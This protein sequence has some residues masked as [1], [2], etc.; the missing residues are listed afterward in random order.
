MPKHNRKRT[1]RP[2]GRLAAAL[3]LFRRPSA[4]LLLAALGVGVIAAVMVSGSAR[5]TNVPTSPANLHGPIKTPFK[6]PKRPPFPAASQA[7][8]EAAR[9]AK[10]RDEAF[11]VAERVVELLPDNPDALCLLGSVHHRFACDEAAA[12]LWQRS[13]DIDPGFADAHYSFGLRANS[14]GDF[15]AAENHLRT[16]LAIDPAWSDVPLPLAQALLAQ[17]KFK[18]AA[19]LLAPFV[20][21]YPASLEGWYRLGQAYHQLGE[22]EQARRCHLEAVSLNPQLADAHHGAA[23]ALTKLGQTEEAERH[24]TEFRRLREEQLR[25][26][27]AEQ[28]GLTDEGRLAAAAAKTHLTAGR[29]FARQGQ[30]RKAEQHWQRA[31]DLDPHDHESRLSLCE[32]YARQGQHSEVVPLRK[33]LCDLVPEDPRQWLNLGIAYGNIDQTEQADAAI[34]R[35]IELAPELAEPYAAL[36]EI[37]LLKGRNVQE[38]I[39][40]AEKAAAL[41][42]VA[43]HYYLLANAHWSA[44][45]WDSARTAL[46]EA[47]RLAPDEREYRQAYTRLLFESSR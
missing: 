33:A 1:V 4:V 15:P 44:R 46:E 39:R 21:V 43:R 47:I 3:D 34:R 22:H 38:A 19:E 10:L 26:G 42:P 27:R 36:A 11:D 30:L 29:I 24:F 16:A 2:S 32:F 5:R 40:L 6:L 31:A 17:N 45:Q 18:E 7:S 23:L 13:L 9:I 25:E 12:S 35:A 8:P 28:K 14:A 37:Q 20:E 41:A